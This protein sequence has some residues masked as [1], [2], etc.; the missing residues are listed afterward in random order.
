MKN[1]IDNQRRPVTPAPFLRMSTPAE[2]SAEDEGD[3]LDDLLD[4]TGAVTNRS[5]GKTGTETKAEPDPKPKP[6]Q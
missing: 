4:E 1:P 3:D 5:N 6:T 2:P